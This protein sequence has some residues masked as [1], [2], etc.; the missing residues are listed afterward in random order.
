M[1]VERDRAADRRRSQTEP[2]RPTAD[3]ESYRHLTKD[4]AYDEFKRIFRR[5]PDL[6][7]SITRRGPPRVV[8]GRAARRPS[9]PS[10]VD[11]ASSRRQ[12][13]V[14]EVETAG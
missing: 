4:D 1:K 12:Q 6:V 3:V 10:T 13:G 9:S 11:G 2:R 5:N 7:S 8:P 14:D